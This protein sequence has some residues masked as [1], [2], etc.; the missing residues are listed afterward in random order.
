MTQFAGL[1]LTEPDKPRGSLQ[2]SLPAPLQSRLTMCCIANTD[3]SCEGDNGNDSSG[4]GPQ[5]LWMVCALPGERRS[6]NKVD[7]A[8][9]RSQVQ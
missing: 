3:V 5:R 9:L 4:G 6:L 1:H 7:T 8:T 2:A